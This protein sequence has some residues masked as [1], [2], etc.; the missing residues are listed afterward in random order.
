MSFELMNMK[1]AGSSETH[2]IAAHDH[3]STIAA[4]DDNHHMHVKYLGQ[5]N[6]WDVPPHRVANEEHSQDGFHH[7]NM[8]ADLV[9]MLKDDQL[10]SSIGM[11]MAQ[12]LGAAED[13]ESQNHANQGGA[14]AVD[15]G[16]QAKSFFESGVCRF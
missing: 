8:N 11:M 14:A 7:T 9:V 6:I 5:M 15:V 2:E 4:H 10:K 16:K 1:M 13:S 12:L 3:A